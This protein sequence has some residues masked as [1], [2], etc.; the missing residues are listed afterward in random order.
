[1]FKE[2]TGLISLY[3]EKTAAGVKNIY[4]ER[5]QRIYNY[6]GT[7]S[8]YVKA[9]NIEKI[10]LKVG[11]LYNVSYVENAR[12]KII[13]ARTNNITSSKLLPNFRYG[14]DDVHV[15]IFRTANTHISAQQLPLTEISYEVLDDKIIF[16]IPENVLCN[17]NYINTLR[18][19][20]DTSAKKNNLWADAIS[21]YKGAAAAVKL[22][23]Y[24]LEAKTVTVADTEDMLSLLRDNG[25]R[26]KK[27]NDR[28]FKLTDDR[29]YKSGEKTVNLGDLIM[30]AQK[31]Q[32]DLVL[33]T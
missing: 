29:F 16:T 1:M 13:L 26:I 9:A 8:L 11:D 7:G 24:R 10:G 19:R 27:L 21:G 2:N 4:N 22:D 23:E 33:C 31:Y 6:T 18:R 28:L 5:K 12:N 32:N 14:S 17:R 20:A 30:L 3:S 15:F 25:F